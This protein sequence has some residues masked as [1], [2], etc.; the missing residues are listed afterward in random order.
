MAM[1]MGIGMAICMSM[2]TAGTRHVPCIGLNGH[3]TSYGTT[4]DDSR[5]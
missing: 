2:G 3:T 5:P 1:G 4:Q